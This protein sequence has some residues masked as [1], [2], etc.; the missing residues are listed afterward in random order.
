MNVLTI[1]GTDP[2]GGAG[3][4]VD[5][6]VARDLGAHGLS[7]ITAVVWQNTCGVRGF[8]PM[9]P[10]VVAAQLDAIL[11]DIPVHAIKIGMLGTLRNAEQISRQLQG[12]EGPVVLDPVLTSGDG[13]TSL[14]KGAAANI[15]ALPPCTVLTPNIPEAQTIL[16]RPD[17]DDPAELA[18]ELHRLL[19]TPVLLKVGHL[20]QRPETPNAPLVD[21][22]AADDHLTHLRPLPRIPDDV[23]GTGCQLSTAIACELAR[24]KSLLHAV[25]S[26]RSYLSDRLTLRQRIGQGRPVVVR[27]H[28]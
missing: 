13:K 11:D 21:L 28:A 27:P 10:E 2:S 8:L 19:Q 25:E 20:P 3:I 7:V 23:R 15:D 22:L 6:Q 14:L 1:A 12:F 24:G 18:L 9:A 4:Q 5:L 17:W 26:A 16:G